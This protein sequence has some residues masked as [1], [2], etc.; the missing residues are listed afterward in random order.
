MSNFIVK[1][2]FNSTLVIFFVSSSGFLALS[3][4]PGTPK[5]AK[6]GEKAHYFD[7]DRVSPLSKYWKFI[8]SFSKEGLGRSSVTERKVVDEIM[9]AL[10]Y[11]LRLALFSTLL[12]LLISLPLG[13]FCVFKGESIIDNFI[14][15]S[16][17]LFSS[18][19]AI[20]L[21]PLL[22]VVFSICLGFLPVSGSENFKSLLLPSLTLSI[23]FS[24]YLVRMLRKSLKEEL[25]KGYIFSLRAR[26]V[27]DGRIIISH[28][29]RN[30]IFPILTVVNLRLGSLI[31]GAILTE[32]LFSWPGVGRLLVRSISGR[33]Y[34][35]AFGIII[36]SSLTYILL[37]LIADITYA[38][39]DPR[40]RY[41][42]KE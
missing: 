21:G 29:L 11:S 2:I 23:P 12:S 15:I 9:D 35:L 13:L 24:A 33:D 18:L 34:N 27:S 26:G 3:L 38:I 36:L 37:N 10:P 19:P 7:K 6:F 39:L 22:V 4:L 30:S 17:I 42:Y 1:R 32:T 25:K 14:F 41:A 31:T 8:C 40:V 5:E 28:V 20:S 16:S